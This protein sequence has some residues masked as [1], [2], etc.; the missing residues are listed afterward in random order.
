[1]KTGFCSFRG[2]GDDSLLISSVLDVLRH[3]ADGDITQGEFKQILQTQIVNPEAASDMKSDG[4]PKQLDLHPVF[5]P[6]CWN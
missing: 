3:F 4:S 1:M 2:M 6:P 5:P